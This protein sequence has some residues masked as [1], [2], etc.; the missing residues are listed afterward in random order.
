M[1]IEK[2][3]HWWKV[4]HAH[5]DHMHYE[6][7]NSGYDFANAKIARDEFITAAVEYKSCMGQAVRSF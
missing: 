3:K 4:Y 2:T 5:S 7:A 1:N 6:A